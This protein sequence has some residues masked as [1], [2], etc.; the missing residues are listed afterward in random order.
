MAEQTQESLPIVLQLQKIQKIGI[1]SFRDLSKKG[2]LFRFLH[3]FRFQL[4]KLYGVDAP[5]VKKVSG[6][7]KNHRDLTQDELLF[8]FQELQD[9]INWLQFFS[10]QGMLTPKSYA[11]QPPLGKNVFIIHGHD[12][13]NTL[14][15]QTLLQNH[16]HLNPVLMM[17]QPGMSRALLEKYEDIA[18]T[19][20]MA[21]AL[22]S[23]DDLIRNHETDY[24]QAR[25]NVIFE[26]GWFVGRLGI[27]R[28]CLLLQ[29]G[30]IVHSDIDG[31][32]RI[33][34]KEN[35]EDKVMDIQR[36]LQ[37]IGLLSDWV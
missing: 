13:V 1:E 35:I 12:E 30:T 23:K 18:S 11:S 22:M 10:G 29:E 34:F 19:C 36:E 32:S 21:F 9:L 24:M 16:F 2:N 33:H 15:L 31:I 37:V 25:P 17:Q 20:A 3:M 27:S 4:G 28:V 26:A 8:L 5:I 6:M 7:L 14:R